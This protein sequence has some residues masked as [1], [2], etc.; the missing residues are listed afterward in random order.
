[1]D[2]KVTK[3]RFNEHWTYD[4]VKYLCFVLVAIALVSL[5]FSV[6]ARRLTDAEELKI[7]FYSTHNDVLYP[8]NTGEDLRDY[9]L[10]QNIADS[11]YLDNKVEYYAFGTTFADKQVASA[12]LEADN[13]MGGVD[14]LLLPILPEYFDEDGELLSFLN[15]F[16]YFVGVDYFIP[17]DEVIELEIAKNNPIAVELKAIFEEH[18][19]YFY[20]CVKKTPNNEQTDTIIHDSTVRNYGIN[21]NSFDL[22][23]V[24]TLVY[25]NYELIG[26]EKSLYA[27]GIRRGSASYAES[28]C[29][30]NWFIQNYIPD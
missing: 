9:I 30:I 25:D 15:T 20:Q 12:K 21:L 16:E 27:F 4:W 14:I 7:V 26:E 6:T 11:E 8:Y 3:Q 22:D 10:A 17:I 18:P 1:M 2:L 24:N 28:L 5:V 29:F 19:E 23:K 13:N